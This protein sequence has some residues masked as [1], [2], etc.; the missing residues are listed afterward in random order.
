MIKIKERNQQVA[1]P[2]DIFESFGTIRF[3]NIFPIILSAIANGSILA[4]DE[5][6]A[7]G[8]W[9]L[10]PTA[11]G[12]AEWEEAAPEY[13]LPIDRTPGMKPNPAKF[14]ADGYEDESISV[15]LETLEQNP[16]PDPEHPWAP[17]KF[18]L[19]LPASSGDGFQLLRIQLG[20]LIDIHLIVHGC[21][22]LD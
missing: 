13:E 6:D 22:L 4:I 11:Y 15:Q 2:A 12:E 5:L 3:L 17:G 18:Q 16:L 7:S 1:I 10:F 9:S 20:D 8:S 19:L 21:Y 14:T